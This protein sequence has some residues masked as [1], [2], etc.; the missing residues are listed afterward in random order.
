MTVTIPRSRWKRGD[1]TNSLMFEPETNSGCVLYWTGIVCEVGHPDMVGKET[2]DKV[3]GHLH[4]WPTWFIDYEWGRDRY[5][6]SKDAIEL[7][8]INDNPE[9]TDAD[10]EAQLS[11]IFERNNDRLEFID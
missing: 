2:P 11:A 3:K 10:R 1:N 4:Y 9:L 8:A 7:T 5:I 6:P